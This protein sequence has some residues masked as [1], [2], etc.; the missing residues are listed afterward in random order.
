MISWCREA[1]AIATAMI[2]AIA[3]GAA[4]AAT[5]D[6]R[7]DTQT[8]SA[9]LSPAVPSGGVVS[10]IQ[11]TYSNELGFPAW[12]SQTAVVITFPPGAAWNG[13]LFPQCDPAALARRGPAACPAGSEFATAQVSAAVG[14][15][16]LQLPAR[17]TEFVGKPVQGLPTQLYDVV[18]AIGPP[19]VLTGLVRNAANGFSID[20]DLSGVPG[21]TPLNGSP[22]DIDAVHNLDMHTSVTRTVN[23]RRVTT[24]LIVAP[25]VCD[26]S[27]DFEFASVFASGPPL[28]SQ[29]QQAC[30]RR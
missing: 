20:L 14:L 17:M 5:S 4:Q 10:N 13:A 12:R 24:P 2:A 23:G 3:P 30:A 16:L 9:G 29:A 19:F 1:A 8:F 26:G 7:G 6:G 18:P 11:M 21:A 25:P 22:I 28:V 15:Q 27:W